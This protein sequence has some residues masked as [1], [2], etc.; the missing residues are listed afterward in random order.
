MLSCA[1][2][3]IHNTNYIWWACQFMYPEHGWFHPEVRRK[4]K[5]IFNSKSVFQ[6]RLP[7]TVPSQFQ[8][9]CRR[10][11]CFSL[12]PDGHDYTDVARALALH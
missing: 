7:V 2:S 11:V 5:Q 9:L 12:Y 1:V 6:Y 4:K 3:T 10:E 8:S